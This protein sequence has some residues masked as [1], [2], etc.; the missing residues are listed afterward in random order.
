[1]LMGKLVGG[2]RQKKA[3]KSQ[4]T[5]KNTQTEQ[6]TKKAKMECSINQEKG[7]ERRRR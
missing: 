2:E 3:K 1:M 4:K 7:G 6:W 5:T